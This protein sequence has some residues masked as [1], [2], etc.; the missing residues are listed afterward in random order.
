MTT[1][2]LIR[3]ALHEFGGHRIAGRTPDVHLSPDGLRQA[4]SLA[5]R[6]K[7]VKI[8]A[9]YASPITRCQET[10]GLIATHHDLE[11]EISEVITEL[12][13]G[14]WQGE[15]IAD[16][17]EQDHWRRFNAFRSGTRAPNG[18]LFLGTQLRVVRFLLDLR[19]RHPNQTVA[20]V[21]HADVIRA[22]LLH[23]LGMPM[24]HFLRLEIS[25]ASVTTVAIAPYGPWILGV[26]HTGNAPTLP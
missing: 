19:D 21:S 14:D 11:I 9:I 22:A 12:D 18:E 23:F 16:L 15:T 24:D 26:N 10:A 5:D 13:F 20:V 25:P 7:K 2:L 6:L 8:D 4:T 17:D 3:H 1:F